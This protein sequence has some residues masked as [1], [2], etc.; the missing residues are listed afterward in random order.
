MTALNILGIAL[1]LWTL[2]VLWALIDSG[3]LSI[4]IQ[5]PAGITLSDAG[6][7]LF[8]VGIGCLGL[9]LFNHPPSNSP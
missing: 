8:L 3:A 1:I 2:Y 5:N 6:F 7:L 4:L 9:W